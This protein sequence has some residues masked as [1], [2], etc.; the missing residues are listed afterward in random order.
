[1]IGAAFM[2][3]VLVGI[4]LAALVVALPWLLRSRGRSR[5]Q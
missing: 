5:A 1:M 3:G 4:S 2:Q